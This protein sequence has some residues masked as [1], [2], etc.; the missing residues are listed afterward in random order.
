MKKTY[1]AP[2]VSICNVKATI[3]AASMGLSDTPYEGD[4]STAHS[5]GSKFQWDDDDLD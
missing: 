5:K 4:L 3:M 1:I 2:S